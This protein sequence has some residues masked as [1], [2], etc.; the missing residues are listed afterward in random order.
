MRSVSIKPYIVGRNPFKLLTNNTTSSDYRVK[1][2]RK[3]QNILFDIRMIKQDL[4]DNYFN[5][6][7]S[8]Y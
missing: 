4:Q 6:A 8:K 1:V 3:L 2:A 7:A 5:Y